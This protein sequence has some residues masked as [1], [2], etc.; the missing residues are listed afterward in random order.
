MDVALSCVH[1]TSGW[2]SPRPGQQCRRPPQS[3]LMGENISVQ[4]GFTTSFVA[5]GCKLLKHDVVR[6]PRASTRN[7]SAIS[8]QIG[9]NGPVDRRSLTALRRVYLCPHAYVHTPERPRNTEVRMWRRYAPDSAHADSYPGGQMVCRPPVTN[10]QEQEDPLPGAGPPHAGL[11]GCIL[12]CAGSS[13]ATLPSPRQLSGPISVRIQVFGDVLR[14]WAWHASCHTQWITI[15]IRGVT[16][17][18]I[19]VSDTMRLPT[20]E[21]E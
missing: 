7:S 19:S 2:T 8:K 18:I 11:R 1:K 14:E 17:S 16:L 21:P 3:T 12:S 4:S 10:S 13:T 20:L 5:R 6:T 15:L 9:K